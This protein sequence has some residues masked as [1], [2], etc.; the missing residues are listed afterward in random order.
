MASTDAQTAKPPLAPGLKLAID[1]GPLLAFFVTYFL[2]GLMA[3]T[4]VVMATTVVALA[5]S[6]ALVRRIPMVP[7]ISALVIMVFGGLTIWLDNELFIKM[8]PTIINGLFAAVLLGGLAFD[9]A[10][11]KPLFEMAF[12]LTEAGW[13]RLSLRWALF[14]VAMAGLNEVVWRS[15]STDAW[16]TFKVFG[17]LPLTFLF[18]LSQMPF[19]Q[20]HSPPAAAEEPAE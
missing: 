20:R 19:I 10:L 4:A 13:K 11:L 5:V 3:A 15:L 12:P 8:K 16:V 6:Y 9:K 2:A 17:L 18:A 1:M 14:F 7:L